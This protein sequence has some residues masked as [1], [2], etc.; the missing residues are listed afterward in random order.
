MV[1]DALPVAV[2]RPVV[3][4]TVFTPASDEPRPGAWGQPPMARRIAFFDMDQTVLGAHSGF[5]YLRE[6]WRQRL[7][8]WR[9]WLAFSLVSGIYS[10]LNLPL[11]VM[12]VLH[13]LAGGDA[14]SL[15]DLCQACYQ[16]A[17]LQH[18]S[19]RAVERLRWH[20]AQGDV[21]VL[22]SAATQFGVEPVARHLGV[23]YRCTELEVLG[24]RLTGRTLGE[25][26]YG[27]G[28]LRWAERI[29]REW[30]IRLEECAFYTDSYSDRRLMERVGRPVAANPDRRLRNLA[31]SRGWEIVSFD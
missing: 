29:A 25:V 5:L 27:D 26:C 24:A 8:T 1:A 9:E 15:R 6:R 2:A 18:L 31:R 17:L 12:N 19:P 11:S 28:K 7:P 4:A 3:T 16:E 13:R 23:F 22:L 30:I 14:A 10:A 21:V 20:E